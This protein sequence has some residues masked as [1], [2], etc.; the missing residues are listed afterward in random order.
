MEVSRPA[1]IV[2]SHTKAVF[3]GPTAG[4]QCSYRKRHRPLLKGS[5]VENP[6]KAVRRNPWRVAVGTAG[7]AGR[8]GTGASGEGKGHEKNGSREP[9]TVI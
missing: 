1:D 2:L 8:P 7:G 5:F 4:V 6:T 3:V 9:A